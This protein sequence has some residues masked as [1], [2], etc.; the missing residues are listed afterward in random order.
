MGGL[1]VIAAKTL[2]AKRVP[3]RNPFLQEKP[4]AQCPNCGS[5]NGPGLWASE[6]KCYDCGWIM[7]T[8]AERVEEPARE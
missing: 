4:A 1:G 5:R 7:M 3:S 6:W 8:A 2:R